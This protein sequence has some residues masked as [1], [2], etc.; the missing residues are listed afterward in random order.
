MPNW[1]DCDVYFNGDE[2]DVV[3]LLDF[4]HGEDEETLIDFNK[5][6]PMPESL[7]ITSGSTVDRAMILLGENERELSNMMTYPWAIEQGLDTEEKMLAHLEKEVSQEDLEMGRIA[8][9]NIEKYGFQDWYEW[10]VKNWGTK[11]PATSQE[12]M[13]DSS[14][15]F[16]TA[17]SPATPVLQK[18]SELFPDVEIRLE[19]FEQGMGFSGLME[20]SGG[21]LVQD[22]Y[23]DHYEGGR[24]G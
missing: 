1:C 22:V 2:E 14:I 12:M 13:G 6:I 10:S 11:W 20:W 5:I 16:S 7:N 3:K 19:Y 24:G 17:W 4:I 18:L 21:E 15:S 23:D 9:S 8:I